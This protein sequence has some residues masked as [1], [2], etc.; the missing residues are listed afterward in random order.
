MKSLANLFR[1][2]PG[3]SSSHTIAPCN[4]A[5]A[6]KRFA[7]DVD[8]FKVT[9]YG[10]LAFT[11]VGH[12]SDEAIRKALGNVTFEFDKVTVP[13]WP[14]TMKFE[15]FKDGKRVKDATYFSLGGGQIQS[16]DDISVN[17]KETYPFLCLQDILD[18]MSRRGINDFKEFCLKFEDPGIDDYLMH[19]TKTMIETVDK[20]LK[21]TGMLPANDNPRLRYYRSAGKIFK[22][23][24]DLVGG[25]GRRSLFITAYAYAVAESSSAGETVVTSP[26]CGSSG[27]LPSVLYY[28]HKQER[29][30]LN[31]IRDALYAAGIIG[32]VVKQNASI[33]GSVGGCA[34]E[35][36]TASAMAAAALC[37]LADLTPYQIE[38]A[39]EVSMEHFLGLTCDPVDG[40]VIIPCIERNG[41]GA[42]HG[43]TSYLYAR[44]VAPIRKNQVSF[45]DV[46]AAMKITG[47]S[48]TSEYKETAQ[49]GLAKILE[50]NC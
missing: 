47:D 42:I 37:A 48:L 25:E 7:G 9:F 19:V 13:P 43:Y 20:G 23:A 35:I 6:F 16:D 36:G 33:A 15:A 34:A 14:L 4:A 10:S 11:G 32:N 29:V 2:G 21:A 41:M 17:E 39:S 22:Q 45:D 38:Y 18:F 44:F 8:A 3:P 1:V 31:K 28:A 49:G 26:T 24:H 27:V 40:Y 46:V 30:P 12:K 50:K 5:L